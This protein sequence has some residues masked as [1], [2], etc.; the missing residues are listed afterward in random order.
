M[1]DAAEMVVVIVVIIVGLREVTEW[2]FRR[3]WTN[4]AWTE[5]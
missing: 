2:L 3:V 5:A 4:G 1:L